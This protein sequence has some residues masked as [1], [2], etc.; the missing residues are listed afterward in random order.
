M[1]EA[2]ER[3]I[4]K[5][6]DTCNNVLANID[7]AL[8]RPDYESMP[9][10]TWNLLRAANDLMWAYRRWESD[11]ENWV[12]QDPLPLPPG[13]IPIPAPIADAILGLVP[14]PGAA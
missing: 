6:A 10:A 2:Q 1:N 5:I 4:A 9:Y 11:G 13:A 14:G 12:D 3:A 7:P 8:L